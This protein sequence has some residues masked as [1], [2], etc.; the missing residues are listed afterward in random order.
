M[1]NFEQKYMHTTSTIPP[2]LP[3][4]SHFLTYMILIYM[5]Y[6]TAPTA[7]I[8]FCTNIIFILVESF[9]ILVR[10]NIVVFE[11]SS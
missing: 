2:E 4:N 8:Y 7:L 5:K 10:I 3:T 1:K 9:Y 11:I 6:R